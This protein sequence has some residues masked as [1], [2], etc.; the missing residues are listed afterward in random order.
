[1]PGFANEIK[2]NYWLAKCFWF[3]IKK[4]DQFVTNPSVT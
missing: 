4:L 3:F 2:K 1:L